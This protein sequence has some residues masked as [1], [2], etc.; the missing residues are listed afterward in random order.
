MFEHVSPEK[1]GI[2]TERIIEFL[3][4]L[5][6]RGAIMHS[7][8]ITRYGKTVLEKY[9]APFHKDFNHRMYSSTKSYTAIGIGLL[10]E[11]GKL[12]LDERLVDIFPDKIDGEANEY[13]KEQTVRQMLTMTTVGNPVNWFNDTDP[14]RVHLY[15]NKRPNPHPAGTIWEYDSAGSQ[16][17]ATIVEKRSGMELMAY[18][19]SKL[20]DKMGTFKNAR[21]LKTRN[22]DAWGDSA[23]LC[24]T[25]DAVS[26]AQ[27]LMD[28]GV[29]QG[30]RLMNE[31][32]VRTATSKVVDNKSSWRPG[33]YTHGYGYQIWRTEQ[34][35]FSFLGMGDELTI[36]LPDY[37][38]IISTTADHQG[39]NN[40]IRE[41]M[42][43]SFF[44]IIVSNVKDGELPANPEAEAR[45][46]EMTKDL[47]LRA[48]E[49]MADSSFREELDGR[50]YICKNNPMGITRFS[51]KFD[52]ADKGEFRYTNAQGDKV[53]PFGV[54]HN[55]FGKF[56]QLGYSNGFGGLRTTDGF[57]YDDAVSFAWLEDKK[58][59]IFVQIID[60]YFGLMSATFA[61]RDGHAAAQFEKIGEDFLNEYQGV[62]SAELVK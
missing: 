18:L 45:L 11:E 33:V 4:K 43:S 61:F 52:G 35:G 25:R 56:P 13:L 20:F 48:L 44:D 40:L 42:V 51:F 28:G 1:V 53:I 21:I 16:V 50:E 55:V 60:N 46:A 3:E 59:M 7:M 62:L 32:F 30:E 38:I 17:L 10:E 12:S 19:K 39:T 6:R 47:K 54:N 8:I 49:G 37:G 14:D 22:G 24:T 31:E 2:P 15:M 29:W 27:L 34:N 57:M 36:A 58:L 9:W 26:F 23:L 41:M 5:E